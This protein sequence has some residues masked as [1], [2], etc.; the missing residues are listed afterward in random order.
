MD[1]RARIIDA[2]AN[3]AREA[4]RVLED[5]ARFALDDEELTESL[6]AL[7]HG[8]TAA[9]GALPLDRRALLTARDTP[10]DVGTSISNE[11]ERARSSHASVVAA[12]GGRL[13]ESLRSLEE[14]AKTL[15]AGGEAFEALRYRSYTLA[16]EIEQRL[17]RRQPQVALCVLVTESL[18]PGGDW[19]R[20]AEAAIAGGAGVLQLR[21][22][23]LPGREL[24][25][26]AGR[27]VEIA[28]CRARIV[29]NDRVDVALAAGADGV[30]LGQSDL[31]I[32]DARRIAGD[33]LTIGVSCATIEHALDAARAGA[34]YIGLGPMFPSATKPKDSLA[35]PELVSAVLADERTRDL[36]HFA[37]S[38]IDADRARALASVG[39]RG[40]AVSSAV[41]GASDPEAAARAIAG[42]IA[43]G[44]T[45]APCQ[46]PSS[47]APST[48]V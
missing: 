25:E 39:C 26:R 45:L 4:V 40:V 22:K 30:H 44:A 15:G 48:T 38:G 14:T 11:T 42:A 36:P 13:A 2:S 23:D 43:A 31:S 33:G 37:I 28:Q 20:V 29:V 5:A 18:C 41:C 24:A 9:I 7:R 19:Q 21:E 34:D 27:L 8:L 17:R 35:G 47:S 12:A 10:G 3:R 16:A 6:K 32:A 46:S 1:P